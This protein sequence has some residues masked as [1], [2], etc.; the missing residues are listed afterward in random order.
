MSVK[1]LPAMHLQLLV[2]IDILSAS[3][4]LD[5]DKADDLRLILINVD[6]S[7]EKLQDILPIHEVNVVVMLQ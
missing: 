6:I 5:I 3:C 7:K 1:T 2:I 4:F